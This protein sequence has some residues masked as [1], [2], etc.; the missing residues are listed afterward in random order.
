VLRR[1]EL[2]PFDADELED[3]RRGSADELVAAGL[4]PAEAFLVAVKRIGSLAKA[5]R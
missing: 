2:Q 3:H 4:S 1:R 5:A